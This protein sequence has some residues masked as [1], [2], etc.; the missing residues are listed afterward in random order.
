MTTKH[1]PFH[2]LKAQA[3]KIAKTV[4]QA[5]RGEKVD[6]KFAGKLLEARS[7]PSLSV[8]VVMDDKVL[9]IDLPWEIIR[10]TTEA[11]LS[12]YILNAMRESRPSVN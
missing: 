10:A 11:A 9:K 6:V 7:R 12:E 5:E 8:G 2:V 3:D 4:K 1:S